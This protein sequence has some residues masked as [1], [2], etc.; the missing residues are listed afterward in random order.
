M[1]PVSSSSYMIDQIKVVDHTQGI[2]QIYIHSESEG[3]NIYGFKVGNI[4]I[5]HPTGHPYLL[6]GIIECE[7]DKIDG[8]IRAFF[9]SHEEQFYDYIGQNDLFRTYYSFRFLPQQLNESEV[10]T[11]FQ[12]I[13]D[14]FPNYEIISVFYNRMG[15]VVI[16]KKEGRYYLIYQ[17][18][19]AKYSP[20]LIV[21]TKNSYFFTKGKTLVMSEQPPFVF[22]IKAPKEVYINHERA[23]LFKHC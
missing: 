8:F 9:K 3:H 4:T 2:I 19:S 12:K 16:S 10:K 7:F 21:P 14:V 23:K 20:T 1:T 13:V 6:R 18:P 22:S 17:D 5:Q 11:S 15:I